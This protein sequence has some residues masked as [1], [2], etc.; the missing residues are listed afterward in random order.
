MILATISDPLATSIIGAAVAI[1]GGIVT[2]T[3]ALIARRMGKV[4][5]TTDTI[6]KLI[7]SASTVQLRLYTVAVRR[8]ATLTNS[9]EDIAVALEADKTLK[10]H[11]ENQRLASKNL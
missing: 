11:E 4:G 3:L 7:N 9:T 8:I 10:E 5:Q 1:F 6:H 2:V